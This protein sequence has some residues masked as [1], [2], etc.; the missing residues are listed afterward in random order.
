M[1]RIPAVV[2]VRVCTG[3]GEEGVEMGLASD[4]GA[5]GSDTPEDVRAGGTV[6][7]EGG[8]AVFHCDLG[9]A[10][11][12]VVEVERGYYVVVAVAVADDRVLVAAAA[13]VDVG[14][15]HLKASPGGAQRRSLRRR[16]L[17][18]GTMSAMRGRRSGDGEWM[19]ESGVCVDGREGDE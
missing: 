2:V 3:G 4:A 8:D 1:E 7:G 13:A 9:G 5:A 17:R 11:G 14:L 15:C 10:L 6:A 16:R 19:E 18:L 12:V